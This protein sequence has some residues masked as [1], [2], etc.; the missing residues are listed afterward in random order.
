[1]LI[2]LLGWRPDRNPNAVI[3]GDS[4]Y[5]LKSW[6]MTPNIPGCTGIGRGQ[7]RPLTVGMERYL[8]SFRKTRFIVENTI[9]I[10]KNEYPIL[11]YGLI[12]TEP[13][14]VSAI[15]L[16]CVALHNMQNEYVNGRY[17]NAFIENIRRGNSNLCSHS[18]RA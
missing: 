1:M 5:P 3:L 11:K 9:G 16:A 12:I 18:L 10:L 4:A 14:K 8:R 15:T 7:R 6:L 17:D 13:S 2:S